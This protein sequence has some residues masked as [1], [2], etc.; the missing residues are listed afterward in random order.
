MFGALSVHFVLYVHVILSKEIMM[1]LA[2]KESNMLLIIIVIVFV[3][4]MLIMA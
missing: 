2:K 1:A 4:L 3:N